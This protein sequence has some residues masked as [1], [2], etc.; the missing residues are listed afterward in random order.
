MRACFNDHFGGL[1]DE[2]CLLERDTNGHNESM[3]F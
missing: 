3:V 2:M 1:Y